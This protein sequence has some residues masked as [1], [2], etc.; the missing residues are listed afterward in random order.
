M[1]LLAL[2]L[3]AYG[4]FS[5]TTL[6]LSG[7]QHGLHLVYGPNEAGKS[8]ALRA[9][10]ALLYGID[11]RTADNFIHK[12]GDMR[13]GGRLQ[14]S[15]GTA[16][17]VRR[18]K[19]NKNTLQGPDGKPLEEAVLER[20][21][22]GVE[23]EV[24]LSM[25][26]M[27]HGRLLEG[28]KEILRGG[29]DVGQALFTASTGFTGL[30]ELC[31]GL[32]EEAGEL[33]KPRG[34]NQKLNVLSK[35]FAELKKQREEL[36]LRGADWK[37][38]QDSLQQLNERREAVARQRQQKL[39]EKGR[40][41][42]LR[43][44]H[45]LIAERATWL[46]VLG[47]LANA[48]LLPPGFTEQRTSTWE[49]RERTGLNV[50]RLERER[51]QLSQELAALA[52]H[53]EL[54]RRA[55]DIKRLHRDSGQYLKGRNDIPNLKG[56]LSTEEWEARNLLKALRPHLSLEEGAQQL[57]LAPGRTERIRE[58]GNQFQARVEAPKAA[59]RNLEAL[60]DEL[61]RKRQELGT[62]PEVRETAALRQALEQAQKRG[63]VEA[64][65][66]ERLRKLR[67]EEQQAALEL[68]RLGLWQGELA[69]LERLAI[70]SQESVQ[71][72]A[73]ELER[74]ELRQE[75]HEREQREVSARAVEARREL[76][77]FERAGE[78]PTEG[79]LMEA[80]ALRDEGWKLV[81]LTWLEGK[82]LAEQEA[83]FGG[84][85]PLPEAFERRMH[86]ADGVAD[87]LRREAARVE[88]RVTLNAAV[89][90]HAQERQ[91]LEEAGGELARQ[92]LAYAA[93]WK[94]LW[95]EARIEPLPPVE[96]RAWLARHAALM[97]RAQ[98][99]RELRQAVGELEGVIAHHRRDVSRELSLVGAPEAGPEEQLEA[100]L[101]R[102]RTLLKRLEANARKRESLSE[103]LVDLEQ[104]ALPA[105][106]QVDEAEQA[107]REWRE[108]WAEAV[109]VLG[110]KGADHPSQA[111]AALQQLEQ[112]F[113]HLESAAVFRTRIKGIDADGERFSREVEALC[114]ELAQ[115]LV[116]QPADVAASTLHERW[117]AASQEEAQREALKKALKERGQELER[118]LAERDSAAAK[119]EAC[120]R[121]AGCERYE[122]LRAV[123]ERS[124]KR[125]EADKGLQECSKRLLALSGGKTLEAF[126]TEATAVEPDQLPMRV[127]QLQSEI[128][129]LEE[130]QSQLDQQIGN[131]Q[132]E[133]RRMDGSGRVGEMAEEAQRMLASI[134]SHAERYLKLKL[135]S[136]LLQREID[137]YREKN[138]NPLLKRASHIFAQ[139]SLGSFEGLEAG[140]DD[141]DAQV[142]YG[143]RPGGSKV[144]VEGMSDG[145]RDQLFL[146]LRLASLEQF[147]DRNEP[148]PLILDDILIN[149]DDGRSAATL[150]VLSELSKRTQVVFFTHHEHLVKLA[151]TCVP[152]DVLQVR[153]LGKA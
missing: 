120:L 43:Q 82:R 126:I 66:A 81:R 110:L 61:T 132:N 124:A 90:Q 12:H 62:L 125:L 114:K 78:V 7:G 100:L 26:G 41:E 153:Q 45:P 137:S 105:Q 83:A 35:Q 108:Q 74:L 106:R 59:T 44:A 88:R 21:L 79:D 111:N 34:Q 115:D 8:S 20:L 109:Q 72:F 5:G 116:G 32:E 70:P 71:R 52:S 10:T 60:K 135:A 13:V 30:S 112:F 136:G 58:L 22:P 14:R 65:L 104:K 51:E 4:P 38:L 84:A 146:A 25:F 68:E 89:E 6:D 23:R 101:T 33:F 133:L 2:E 3:E 123:E 49:Q 122:E 46:Q 128:G 11:A 29:G 92:R 152:E 73:S 103:A 144:T 151:R 93:A 113:K 80:R 53:P 131:E 127:E 48:V 85:V 1:R 75:Q 57:R 18:R 94:E 141:G 129:V 147:L 130:Q 145:S 134:K 99:L 16:L 56:R 121:E 107:L 142:L 149:F 98:H 139:L 119:L 95:H 86:E 9:L 24:F 31:K 39:A 63:E 96:M 47:S 27:D 28:G 117:Q 40:L 67:A 36:V 150:R 17:H 118:A 19:G 15:D 64:E 87:R 138:Q 42:R 50:K 91:R 69:A 76:E 54:L 140:Y 77:T 97:K 37:R 55:E 143:L 148:V 102:V